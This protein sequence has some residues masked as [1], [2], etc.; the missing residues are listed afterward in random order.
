MPNV[1]K[2]PV[3]SLS[4]LE[5]RLKRVHAEVAT[6]RAKLRERCARLL[7]EKCPHEVRRLIMDHVTE[8]EWKRLKKLGIN[9]HLP[10]KR[11][12]T[13]L[14]ATEN[15]P[16]NIVHDPRQISLFQNELSSEV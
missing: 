6:Q 2:T 11:G 16:E 4:D 14:G 10:P 7:F 9:D 13:L 8:D 15:L 12:P 3:Q 5:N 1:P